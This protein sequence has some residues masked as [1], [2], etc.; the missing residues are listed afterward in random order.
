MNASL[1]PQEYR[2]KH[3]EPLLL[4]AIVFL[5]LNV[6]YRTWS[7]VQGFDWGGWLPVM[8]WTH[9][10]EPIPS[11]RSVGISYHPPLSDLLGRLIY[12]VYP[13]EVETS[14]ILS[15]LSILGAFLPFARF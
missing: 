13:H 2:W 7:Q 4:L 3:L 1:S 8:H 10:F 14:Q 11:T 15:T 9:W 12:T 5:K 6:I